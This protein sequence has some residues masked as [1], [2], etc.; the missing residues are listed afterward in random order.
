M[1]TSIY[2]AYREF[3]KLE[4]ASSI[5]LLIAALLALWMSNSALEHFYG[6]L[7]HTPISISPLSFEIKPLEFWVNDGLMAI[8]FFTVGLELKRE[9]L[10]GELSDLSKVALPTIAAVGGM[11]VPALI[12]VALNWDNSTTLNGWAIPSATDIAFSLGVLALLGR[13]VPFSLKVFLMALAII[14]DLGAIV[15]IALFYSGHELHLSYLA[16]AAALLV[17][18]VILFHWKGIT[19]LTVYLIVGLF[20]WFFVMKSGIHATLAGV[21]LAFVIPNVTDSHGHNPLHRLEKIL[22]PWVAYGI[23]PIF[24]FVNAGVSFEGM[25]LSILWEPVPLGIV[26]G[27]FLGKQLGVF[28]FTWLTIKL[29]FAKLPDRA[30]WMTIYGVAALCGVGFTMSLF[31]GSMAF[32]DAEYMNQV[33]LGVLL[34]S[35]LSAIVGYLILFAATSGQAP[36]PET[37]E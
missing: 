32:T 35:F 15:I 29:G 34:G 14:D 33:R 31:I 17:V 19:S 25:D 28:G 20:L 10:E 12:Y 30:T 24:A 13:R 9:M 2:N 23:L 16:F 11:A 5:L 6:A 22:H 4:S 8:F 3:V 37:V 26:L 1:L 21:A 36:I 27:L 7:I 18:P